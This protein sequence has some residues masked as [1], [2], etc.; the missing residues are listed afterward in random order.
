[1]AL[2]TGQPAPT[3]FFGTTGPGQLWALDGSG[4]FTTTDAGQTWRVITPPG[5]TNDPIAVM[6]AAY[7]LTTAQGCVE[8]DIPLDGGHPTVQCTKDGGTTW[9]GSAFPSPPDGTGDDDIGLLNADQGWFTVGIGISARYELYVTDN[10]GTSWSPVAMDLPVGDIE[11][12]S[13]TDAWGVAQT[14]AGSTLYRSIDGGDS[15]SPV[16]LPVASQWRGRHGVPLLAFGLPTF[17]GANAVVAVE[18][19]TTGSL[20]VE[21]TSD[22]GATWSALR[23]LSGVRLPVDTGPANRSVEVLPFDALS[24]STWTVWSGDSVRATTDGGARWT[25]ITDTN[26]PSS[27][28]ISAGPRDPLTTISFTDPADGWGDGELPVGT[29]DTFDLLVHTTDGGRRVTLVAWPGG[30]TVDSIPELPGIAFAG[31]TVAGRTLTP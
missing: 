31:T 8:V 26:L 5:G 10:G 19:A 2:A 16:A 1:V 24:S 25:V 3:P 6:N 13:A 15:W 29:R 30:R 9:A 27:I 11:F 22:G 18:D 23:P 4:L 28:R 12:T 7:F 14:G 20:G 21:T 17:F